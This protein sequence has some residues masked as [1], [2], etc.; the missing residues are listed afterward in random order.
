MH[1]PIQ[2]PH[3][4]DPREQS[5]AIVLDHEHQRPDRRLPFRRVMLALWQLRD[6]VSGVTQR[7]QLAAV[8]ERDWIVE[9]AIPSANR[10]LNPSWH[11]A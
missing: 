6:I 10:S 8:R 9:G 3:H 11:V 4:A 7:Y 2:R 5:L 1:R